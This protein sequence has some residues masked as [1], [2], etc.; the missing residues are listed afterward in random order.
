MPGG[1]RLSTALGSPP[2]AVSPSL[3]AALVAALVAGSGADAPAPVVGA[4]STRRG[5]TGPVVD[6]V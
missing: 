3:V 2:V 4:T 6:P 5:E 1:T